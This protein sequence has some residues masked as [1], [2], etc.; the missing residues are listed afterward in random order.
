VAARY[1][2][3]RSELQAHTGWRI[4]PAPRVDQQAVLHV[5]SELIPD[6][7]EQTRNP[8]LDVAGR[9]VRLRLRE[10]AAPPPAAE[11]EE[12]EAE[13]ERRTGFTLA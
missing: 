5:V 9:K 6:S 3:V 8:G 13:L 2:A 7:W 12:V 10:D 11:R 1:E 4:Q